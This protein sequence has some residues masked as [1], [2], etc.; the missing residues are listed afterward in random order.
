MFV[1]QVSISSCPTLQVP[2]STFNL[3]EFDHSKFPIAVVPT[4]NVPPKMHVLPNWY[5]GK[6]WKFLQM[7]PSWRKRHWGMR[8]SN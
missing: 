7:Q 8:V 5:R 1:E 3:Y 2:D 4:Q 6:F